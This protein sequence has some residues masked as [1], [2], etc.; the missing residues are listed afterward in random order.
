MSWYK[1]MAKSSQ[2]NTHMHPHPHTVHHRLEAGGWWTS[3]DVWP[4]MKNIFIPLVH[5]DKKKSKKFIYI[6]LKRLMFFKKVM[7]YHIWVLRYSNWIW[8]LMTWHL[9]SYFIIPL[10]LIF[11]LLLLQY[12][13]CLDFVFTE[14]NSC[15]PVSIGLQAKQAFNCI[16]THSVNPA[17]SAA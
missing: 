16:F 4:L 9:Y 13:C 6:E 2:S 10:M 7:F 1:R 14:N 11:L 15:W 3:T 8:F 17:S 5:G 12:K